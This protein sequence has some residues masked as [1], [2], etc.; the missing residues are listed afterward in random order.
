[1]AFRFA[2]PP[3]WEYRAGQ[4]VDI[5]LL[6]PPET[7]AE[8]NTRGFSISTAPREH[9]IMITTRLRDTDE[10]AIR[11]RNSR[12]TEAALTTDLDRCVGLRRL[13]SHVARE[14]DDRARARSTRECHLTD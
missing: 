1:M 14:A 12:A 10:D 2:K 8:G 3:G 7:D 4:Y 13:E 6:D 11:S 5:S 9:V